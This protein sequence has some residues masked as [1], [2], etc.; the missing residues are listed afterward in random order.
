MGGGQQSSY[1]SSG[2]GGGYGSPYGGVQR[3][4]YGMGNQSPYGSAFGGQSPYGMMQRPPVQNYGYGQPQGFGPMPAGMAMGM[5]APS[6]MPP[7]QQ[8]TNQPPMQQAVNGPNGQFASPDVVAAGRAPWQQQS[9]PT[10]PQS[11]PYA[12][13]QGPMS[14]Y[15]RLDAN[16]YP[17]RTGYTG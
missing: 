3:P 10:V 11:S 7:M 1:G 17:T 14:P 4:M 16:G 6:V 9:Q 13:F 8:G 2:L 12:S 15:W 5:R